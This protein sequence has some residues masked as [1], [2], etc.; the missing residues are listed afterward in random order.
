MLFGV[1]DDLNLNQLNSPHRK[2]NQE[3]CA[4]SP[5]MFTTVLKVTTR[6]TTLAPRSFFSRGNH[7]IRSFRS[8]FETV[9]LLLSALQNE[10]DFFRLSHWTLSR[11]SR[12]ADPQVF[13]TRPGARKCSGHHCRNLK[14]FANFLCIFF[15]FFM[16]SVYFG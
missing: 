7:E 5:I 14:P 9:A 8:R 12:K 11:A 16:V 6:I 15:L 1:R 3:Y 10:N 13:K 2:V 4:S